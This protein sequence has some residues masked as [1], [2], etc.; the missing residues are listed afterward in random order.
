MDA[1]VPI[2]FENNANN[3]E[4]NGQEQPSSAKANEKKVHSCRK[5]CD[6]KF[7]SFK[8]LNRHILTKH[9]EA[10]YNKLLKCKYCEAMVI[11]KLMNKHLRTE[12]NL[13]EVEGCDKRL[14][15]FALKA[16]MQR[17]HGNDYVRNLKETVKTK[18]KEK[19]RMNNRVHKC[20]VHDCN[21]E[22]QQ[23]KE[24]KDHLQNDHSKEEKLHPCE[25]DEC[26]NRNQMFSSLAI[27]KHILSEHET[28]SE[29][30]I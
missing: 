19:N 6:A 30:K 26:T 2:E 28:N 15:S 22:F 23:F 24:L 14:P 13:C 8:L 1:T 16:H 12:H 4:S 21:S 9:R 7:D 11:K 25:Y 20:K 18:K 27:R 29:K 3:S 5:D 10:F 17:V